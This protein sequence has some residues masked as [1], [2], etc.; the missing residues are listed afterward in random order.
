MRKEGIRGETNEELRKE[1]GR[2]EGI[3]KGRRR[4]LGKKEGEREKAKQT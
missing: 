4:M 3:N 2:K 1:R